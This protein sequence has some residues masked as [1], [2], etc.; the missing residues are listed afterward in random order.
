MS[1]IKH[2]RV[3]QEKQKWPEWSLSRWSLI[4]RRWRQGG[5]VVPYPRCFKLRP[6]REMCIFPSRSLLFSV[7]RTLAFLSL[8]VYMRMSARL[9][10]SSRSISGERLLIAAL[11]SPS[12]EHSNKCSPFVR[13]AWQSSFSSFSFSFFCFFPPPQMRVRL[14]GRDNL[15]G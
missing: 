6:P 3:M 13:E 12:S 11:R 1:E 9:A 2:L 10:A 4:L 7:S 14:S 15:R 5:Y 8:N